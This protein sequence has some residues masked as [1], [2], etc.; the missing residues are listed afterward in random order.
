[1]ATLMPTPPPTQEPV[2]KP[3]KVRKD[4]Q[5]SAEERAIF[6]RHK[7]EYMAT[8][9]HKERESLLQNRLLLDLNDYWAAREGRMC[10]GAELDAR[11]DVRGL[12]HY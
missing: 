12:L 3:R 2:R 4:C 1:M 9:T 7:V 11:N 5:Y 10:E 6:D 8:T